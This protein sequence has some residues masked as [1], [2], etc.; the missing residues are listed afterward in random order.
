MLRDVVGNDGGGVGCG[1][2]GSWGGNHGRRPVPGACIVGRSI[3]SG[4]GK[5]GE[6]LVHGENYDFILNIITAQR[7]RP[8][9]MV[10]TR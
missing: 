10:L 2:R 6:T 9:Y 8:F 4:Y 1:V 7:F 3:R 5:N